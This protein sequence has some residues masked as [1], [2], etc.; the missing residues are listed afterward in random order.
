[1]MAKISLKR[2]SLRSNNPLV[3]ERK[4]ERTNGITAK[5]VAKR[6]RSVN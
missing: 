1:M 3:K 6:E 4:K 5:W 2:G